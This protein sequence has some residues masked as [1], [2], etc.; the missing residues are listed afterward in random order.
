[1]LS[2]GALEIHALRKTLGFLRPRVVLPARHGVRV[3]ARAHLFDNGLH[4][5]VDRLA[6][7]LPTPHLLG[8][9]APGQGFLVALSCLVVQH[10]GHAVVVGAHKI[11]REPGS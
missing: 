4:I 2:L 8:Q 5:P 11:Q 7:D 9:R 3:I 1:M 6:N 10:R